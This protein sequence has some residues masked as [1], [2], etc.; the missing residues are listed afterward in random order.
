VLRLLEGRAGRGVGQLA[1]HVDAGRGVAAEA[2]RLQ[3][4]VVVADAHRHDPLLGEAGDR[5]RVLPDGHGVLGV[6]EEVHP[7][8]AGRRQLGDAVEERDLASALAVAVRDHDGGH[9]RL[10]RR[11]D[12]LEPEVELLVVPV[13]VVGGLLVRV[14]QEPPDLVGRERGEV[15]RAHLDR[16]DALAPDEAVAGLRVRERRRDLDG[17]IGLALLEGDDHALLRRS[18]QQ[19]QG[20]EVRAAHQVVLEEG[21][22]DGVERLRLLGVVEPPVQNRAGDVLVHGHDGVAIDEVGLRRDLR[23]LLGRGLV[24]LDHGHL[25]RDQVELLTVLGDAHPHDPVGVEQVGGDGVRGG[26]HDRQVGPRHRVGLVVVGQLDGADVELV[27]LLQQFTQGHGAN[28]FLSCPERAVW[29]TLAF[30][31]AGM[32]TDAL[33]TSAIHKRTR[34]SVPEW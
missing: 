30:R 29:F 2:R 34:R 10:H 32:L 25:Q 11:G 33:T 5:R 20:V 3:A 1:E 9:A 6:D 15:A 12:L 21:P 26:R 18:A 4:R 22:V 13:D 27:I 16:G 8:H 19:E 14:V 28:P 24:Q 7:P 23:L 17:E 31:P